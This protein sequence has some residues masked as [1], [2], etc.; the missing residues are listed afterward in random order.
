MVGTWKQDTMEVIPPVNVLKG[1]GARSSGRPLNT[2]AWRDWE[3]NVGRQKIIHMVQSPRAG[4]RKN[5][6]C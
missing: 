4:I 3:Q 6:F 5:Q 1:K 2:S